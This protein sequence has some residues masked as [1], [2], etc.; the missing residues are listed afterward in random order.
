MGF[1][2]PVVLVLII[3]ASLS[4]A[5]AG[6]EPGA[7]SGVRVG[8]TVRLGGY[9]YAGKIDEQWYARNFDVLDLNAKNDRNLIKRL[10]DSNPKIVIFQQFL[11]NQIAVEQKGAQAVEGYDYERMK[12]WLL[13]SQNGTIARSHRGP[14][15][16]L[17]DHGNQTDWSVHFA[18]YAKSV[19][20]ETGADGLV[21]DEVPLSLDVPFGQLEK[22]PTAQKLQD[23]TKYFLEDISRRLGVPVLINAGQLH[24]RRPNGDML[25]D[26]LGASVGGAW[27]EG[28]IRYYM[29]HDHPHSGNMWE[30]DIASAEKFSSG[31]RYYIAS[32][33]YSNRAELEYAV[34]NYLLAKASDYLVFQPMVR[35][36]P[37]D[38]GG[39]NFG[40]VKN[41]V[42]NNRDIFDVELGCPS[43][44][45]LNKGSVWYRYYDK[46]LVVVNPTDKDVV[47]SLSGRYFGVDRSHVG[48]SVS[49]PPF[50]GRVLI[51]D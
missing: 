34:A 18:S 31:G 36:T 7:L 24:H 49:L 4:V 6:C 37:D 39:F 46:G 12:G 32:A 17:V 43:G 20:S 47:F 25:W 11:T 19:L 41:S 9:F 8:K 30:A 33:A 3:L 42:D 21:L 38:R 23:A 28:W 35:Y 50:G 26:W 2:K 29:A 15:Y 44:V 10:K 13:K 27:H 14:F 1:A 16:L 45:R 40:L 48:G 51:S 5:H 22:Y